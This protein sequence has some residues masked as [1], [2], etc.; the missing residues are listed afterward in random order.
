[1]AKCNICVKRVLPHSFHIQCS[2]CLDFVHINCLPYVSRNDPLYIERHSN[3]WLCTLCSKR[4]FPYNHFDDDVDFINALSENW[5]DE[6]KISCESFCDK[7]FVPFE[8]NTDEKSP[9]FDTDPDIHFYNT[10]HN[11]NLNNCNYYLRSNA[12]EDG[13][14]YQC[15]SGSKIRPAGDPVFQ[16]N[17]PKS[18]NCTSH[19]EVTPLYNYLEHL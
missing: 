11:L 5:E 12:L 8:L 1:M 2:Y 3:A 18:R 4:I 13:I 16:D 10:V 7:V 17:Q 6:L 15:F 9:L 19:Y 14:P